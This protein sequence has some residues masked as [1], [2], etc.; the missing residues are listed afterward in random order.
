MERLL[1]C[2]T[3]KSMQGGGTKLLIKLPKFS[4]RTCLPA[5]GEAEFLQNFCEHCSSKILSECSRTPTPDSSAVKVDLISSHLRGLVD[6]ELA[7]VSGTSLHLSCVLLTWKQKLYKQQAC[8]INYSLHKQQVL[9]DFDAYVNIFIF[10]ALG[11]FLQVDL[12]SPKFGSC[13]HYSFR[14]T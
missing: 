11:G 7:R 3:C 9:S 4:C 14:W 2:Q 5:H 6:G 8:C 13:A 10:P 1:P 12:L